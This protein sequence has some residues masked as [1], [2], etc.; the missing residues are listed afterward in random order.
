MYLALLDTYAKYRACPDHLLAVVSC[1]LAGGEATLYPDGL[2][3]ST[4]VSGY[5]VEVLKRVRSEIDQEKT[6][7]I[8]ILCLPLFSGNSSF[9]QLGNRSLKD[10]LLLSKRPCDIVL[11]QNVGAT[12]LSAGFIYSFP[13]YT[14]SFYTM[15]HVS[16]QW[17]LV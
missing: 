16:L 9:A 5:Q 13:T 15:V 4:G 17:P 6:S 1:Q 2:H 7:R 11:N 10:L 8:D 3:N 12:S 14:N